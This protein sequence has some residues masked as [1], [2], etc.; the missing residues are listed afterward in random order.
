MTFGLF[1]LYALPVSLGVLMIACGVVCGR[2]EVD[3]EL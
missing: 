2:A 3:L 1:M